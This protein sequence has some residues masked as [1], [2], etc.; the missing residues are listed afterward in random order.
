MP[1]RDLRGIDTVGQIAGHQRREAATVADR[2][3]DPL[4]IGLRCRD[5]RHRRGQVRHH[6]RPSE[7]PR[8]MPC[9]LR[10]HR[11]IAQVNVPVVGA[12]DG[13][14]IGHAP[15]YR[16]RRRVATLENDGDSLGAVA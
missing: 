11:A 1:R 9:D 7:L 13:Q 4:P 2:C 8:G 14:A 3:Q 5:A 6:D 10:Q 15:S 16:R 12:A